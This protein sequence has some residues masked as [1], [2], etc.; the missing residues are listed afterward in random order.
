M[1]AIDLI[2][3]N[4]AEYLAETVPS[5]NKRRSKGS[6]RGRK[7]AQS[8]E[9]GDNGKE[10]ASDGRLDDTLVAYCL[11]DWEANLAIQILKVLYNLNI[12]LDNRE[13]DEV[14]QSCYLNIEIEYYILL[15]V[16]GRRG[17]L[18][19]FGLHSA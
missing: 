5:K 16:K 11:D 8:T 4:N 10:E 7:S 9:N 15:F 14:N 6:R 19:S 1:E 17:S 18:F 13:V 12:D 3:K 2:L